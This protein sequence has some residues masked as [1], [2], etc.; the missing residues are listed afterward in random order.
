MPKT[1]IK[2]H[3]KEY[4]DRPKKSKSEPEPEPS[5]ITLKQRQEAHRARH[6]NDKNK[7]SGLTPGHATWIN[8]NKK[9]HENA[10]ARYEALERFYETHTWFGM[11]T[12]WVKN[13]IGSEEE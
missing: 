3:K 8:I 11:K 5:R 4:R 9:G 10:R 2:E 6:P 1:S 13:E 7:K 12:G